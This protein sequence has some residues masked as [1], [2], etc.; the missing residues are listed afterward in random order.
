MRYPILHIQYSYGL[1]R[2]IDVGQLYQ[3]TQMVF[4]T[5][6][7]GLGEQVVTYSLGPYV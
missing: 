5:A 2:W 4:A 3:G 6:S 1:L 7:F